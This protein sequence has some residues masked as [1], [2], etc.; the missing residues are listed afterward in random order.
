M[1]P[2]TS[3]V[4][5][6]TAGVPV[7]DPVP[8]PDPAA[9][10][11]WWRD[12]VLYQVYLRSFADSDSHS[13][14]VGDL[15][16]LRSR[17]RYLADLGVDG[18]WITPFYRSPMAD[19]GYDVADHRDVDPLF[20]DL[21]GF[22]ALLADVHALG[23]KVLL[24]LVPNHSSSAHPAFVAALAAAPG[25]PERELYLFR[26]GR[27]PEASNPPNNW[28]S[29]F[30]GS[31][32]TRVHDGQ[33]YL[34]LFA[35]EQP[36][37]NW[38]HAYVRDDHL[39]TLRF[40]LDRGIDGFRID[41][42]HGLVKKSGLP[43][44]PGD[45]KA[46][47]DTGFREEREPYSWDQEG[48]H[49]IYRDWRRLVDSY[50]AADG[51]SRVLV[52]ETWVADPA[53]LARY[54]RPDE[55]HLTFSFTLLV[56]PW[57]ASAWRDAIHAGRSATAAVGAPPTWVLANHDVVRP[58]S[59]YGGGELGLR[60][61]RAAVLTLL[62]LPGTAFLYQGDELGLPQVDV[63]PKARRDPVW[64][65]SGHT[66]PGR[67]GSRVPMPW[68]GTAP[69]YGFTSPGT[70]PWLPQPGDWAP[71]TVQAQLADPT[72]TLV[73][74]RSALALR[75]ALPAFRGTAL[76][77]REDVPADCLAFDRTPPN[78]A[79][80]PHRPRSHETPSHGTPPH[81]TPPHGIG[82]ARGRRAPTTVTCVVSTAAE[83]AEVEVPGRLMLA[84]NPVGY[85]GRTL[86]L[87]PDTAAWI[88]WG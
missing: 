17:L 3:D 53:R 87:P 10:G 34:H 18:L 50:E 60:R 72:S 2:D 48:V 23:L 54:V 85:D 70:V 24:D 78:A 21:A 8:D 69:P 27:G 13:D 74:V 16:G 80:G 61:A 67:D 25:S 42:T 52:G 19:H 63:P 57:S 77:W 12:A 33:W 88:A 29:V 41:V 55:L 20:G 28:I 7:P 51:R 58:V 15:G 49:E 5:G 47:I 79:A 84:S 40:W 44:N 14:G 68:D 36:D 75:R 9:G 22:D 64:T 45:V 83:D 38:E 86:V 35:P 32:W 43:D 39:S 65:R 76:S 81:E 6:G 66:H 71:L 30:G 56:A 46:S 31:A 37:W 62:A 73:L 82:R 4:P 11:D 26:D 1:R 59:R